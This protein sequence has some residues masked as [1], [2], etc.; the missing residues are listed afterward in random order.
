MKLTQIGQCL[1][2][3]FLLSTSNYSWAKTKVKAKTKTPSSRSNSHTKST[4]PGVRKMFASGLALYKAR[5]FSQALVV[6]DRTLRQYPNHQPTVNLFAKSLYRLDR[7]PE[8]FQLFSKLDLK[9]LDIETSYEY[10]LSNFWMRQYQPA[11]S[12]FQRI[13]EGNALFDLA[14]YYGGIAALKINR[15]LEAET[16]IEKAVVLPLKLAKSR[17]NYLK[18]IQDLKLLYEKKGLALERQKEK[19]RIEAAL[20]K[21]K[22]VKLSSKETAKAVK[23]YKH[24]GFEGVDNQATL[25]IIFKN[26]LI[27]R[28]GYS[29][30]TNT[31]RITYFEFQGGPLISLPYKTG[32]DQAAIGL[33]IAE[34]QK[35][36]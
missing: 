2:L 25:G 6:F 18:H 16:M 7:I 14:N 21:E 23:N 11:L 28:H 24:Q 3:V 9:G 20:K 36:S 33:Q 17:R 15:L 10:A 35:S 8:A 1:G 30:E 31:V 34:K 4:A 32:S 13:P 12:G 22:A 26:Q 27:D 29:E 19:K 5:K